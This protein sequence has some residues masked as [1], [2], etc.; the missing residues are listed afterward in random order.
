MDVFEALRARRSIRKFSTDPVDAQAIDALLHAAM[1]GPSA[2]N[3]MPWE[4]YVITDSAKL[5]AL[6]ASARYANIDAPLAIAVCGNLTRALPLH[7]AGFWIQDCSA[8]TENILL[9]ATA[10]GLGSVW[11]GLHP[12]KQ[13]EKAVSKLLGLSAKQIPLNIIYIGHPAEAPAPRD[14][15]KEEYVHFI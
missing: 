8:A 4:F 6:R 10:M 14:Q 11:C 3:K 2:C 9:A 12:Q 7:L 13:A 1:S 5:A 15:Y